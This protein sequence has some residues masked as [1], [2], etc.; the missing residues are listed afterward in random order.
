MDKTDTYNAA[1]D[2]LLE[3]A[4]TQTQLT[5]DEMPDYCPSEECQLEK[6][7][8]EANLRNNPDVN[9]MGSRG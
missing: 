9:S 6:E 4:K 2:V 8:E 7:V 5:V 1:S 3:G